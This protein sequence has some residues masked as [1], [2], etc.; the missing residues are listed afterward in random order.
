MVLNVVFV[1]KGWNFKSDGWRQNIKD[2]CN[3]YTLNLAGVKRSKQNFKTYASSQDPYYCFIKRV[4]CY[5]QSFTFLRGSKVCTLFLYL[6]DFL[7][8]KN[9]IKTILPFSMCLVKCP[10]SMLIR[11]IWWL[12]AAS[13]SSRIEAVSLITEFWWK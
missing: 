10:S 11:A 4:R 5:H 1:F 13:S 7:V 9:Y 6:I 2:L 3:V 8:F 12:M